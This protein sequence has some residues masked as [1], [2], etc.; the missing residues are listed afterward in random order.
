MAQYIQ[1]HI[2]P[3][4]AAYIAWLALSVALFANDV[5]LIAPGPTSLQPQL[6]ALA[7]FAEAESLRVSLP[8]TVTLSF[9]CS[10]RVTVAGQELQQVDQAK[11]LGLMQRSNCSAR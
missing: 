7:Q 6:T 8:K 9:N 5:V 10:T 4:G 2:A 11:Y 3:T 1:S